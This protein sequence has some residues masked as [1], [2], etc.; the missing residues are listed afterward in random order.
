VFVP[1]VGFGMLYNT[2]NTGENEKGENEKGD[3]VSDEKEGIC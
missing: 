2:G 3:V 1:Y